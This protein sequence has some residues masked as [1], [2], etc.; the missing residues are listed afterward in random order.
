MCSMFPEGSVFCS[1]IEIVSLRLFAI[2]LLAMQA[3]QS[4]TISVFLSYAGVGAYLL[5]G[6]FLIPDISLIL[7]TFLKIAHWAKRESIQV[8]QHITEF[9]RSN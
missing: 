2:Y 1:R 7:W 5:P 9:W 3:R 8:F 6:Y 4:E